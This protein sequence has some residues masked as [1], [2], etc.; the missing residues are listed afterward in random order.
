MALL[1]TLPGVSQ[2]VSLVELIVVK[3]FT[4]DPPGSQGH[5][6][7]SAAEAMTFNFADL[8]GPQEED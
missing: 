4:T 6:S 2:Q 7:D 8:P 5:M 1:E 3:I